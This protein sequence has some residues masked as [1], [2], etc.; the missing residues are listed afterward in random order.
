MV[1]EHDV[2]CHFCLSQGIIIK[3]CG[4]K[5]GREPRTAKQRILF[6]QGYVERAGEFQYHLATG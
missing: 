5:H 6:L 3:R 4:L 2:Q 1:C